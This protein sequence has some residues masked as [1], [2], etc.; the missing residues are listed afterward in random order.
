MLFSEKEKCFFSG[1]S[2]G[3]ILKWNSENY[4]EAKVV[5]NIKA[6]VLSLF[7]FPKKSI[8][9]AGQLQG[10]LHV[11]DLENKKELRHIAFHK[12]GVF[13]IKFNDGKIFLSGG[14]GVLS[15]W[16]PD[17]FNLLKSVPVSTKSIRSLNFHPTKKEL[18]LGVSDHCIYIIDSNSFS[19]KK[20]IEHHKNSVFSVAYSPDGKYLLS[21]SRDA[22]LCVWDVNNNYELISTF[23]A[24]YYTI[25]DIAFN[26][27]NTLIATASRDKTIKIWDA[28]DFSFLKKLDAA[29]GGH[30]N[31]VNKLFWNGNQLISCSDDRSLIVWEVEQH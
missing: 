6:S 5:A 1:S 28:S 7:Y 13:D 21:G 14:D 31:S 26:S 25:N 11:L 3:I 2:E 8:L 4:Q 10:G 15:I 22:H 27:E 16:E 18:A 9:L 20:K 29:E 30:I 19:I 17:D 12:N 24:H 23:P